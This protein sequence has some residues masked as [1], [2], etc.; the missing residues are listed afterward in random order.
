M[1]QISPSTHMREELIGASDKR[2]DPAVSE[3]QRHEQCGQHAEHEQRDE[4][5]G[6]APAQSADA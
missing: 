2:I 6:K 4:C 5:G 3:A 1:L